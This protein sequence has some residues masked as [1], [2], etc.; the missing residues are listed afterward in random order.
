MRMYRKGQE[1]KKNL[2]SRDIVGTARSDRL[3]RERGPLD[4]IQQKYFRLTRTEILAWHF[5]EI[6]S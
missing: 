2:F 6:E 4:V 5:V 1:E 3:V